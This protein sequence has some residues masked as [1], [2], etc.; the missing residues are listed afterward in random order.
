MQG[1]VIQRA[2]RWC[3]ILLIVGLPASLA[4]QITPA[5]TAD[6]AAN[7]VAQV[8]VENTGNDIIPCSFCSTGRMLVMTWDGTTP[9]LAWDHNGTP[10]SQLLLGSTSLPPY[11]P[12][13]PDIVVGNGGEN[14]VVTYLLASRVFLEA[15]QWDSGTSQ[16]VALTSAPVLV[17]NSIS[18]IPNISVDA[19][20]NIVITWTR[21]MGASFGVWAITGD[22]FGNLTGSPV[23][24]SQPDFSPQNYICN[25]SD[26]SIYKSF[27]YGHIVNFSYVAH[28]VN[29]NTMGIIHKTE[30]FSNLQAG[31]ANTTPATIAYTAP[32]ND[33]VG[34]S[35]ITAMWNWN[36]PSGPNQVEI[37]F[38]EIDASNVYYYLRGYHAQTGLVSTLNS[39]FGL[40]QCFNSLPAVT[41]WGDKIFGGWSYNDDVP[42]CNKMD[43]NIPSLPAATTNEVLVRELGFNGTPQTLPSPY[44][45]QN[46]HLPGEQLASSLAGR[47][48][49]ADR[50]FLVHYDGDQQDVI[51]KV[52]DFTSGAVKQ[53][54][55]V[56]GLPT[57]GNMGAEG[58][59]LYPNPAAD[60]LHIRRPDFAAR[61]MLLYDLF[62]SVVQRFNLSEGAGDIQVDVSSV[63]EGAYVVEL[64]AGD[65]RHRMPLRI[66]R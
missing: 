31:I 66:I 12:E 49:F 36:D 45:L 25:Q 40:E 39:V 33:K 19:A 4:A 52:S 30:T 5:A 57:S 51:Y 2:S 58:L 64:R 62:G 37:S 6:A 59:L 47:R 65:R 32:T 53:G 42:G 27:S 7:S 44:Y 21:K 50:L 55:D 60:M 22:I 28:H 16:F 20:D 17:Q 63:S 34:S 61:E 18:Q 29:S 35:R 23:N 8:E 46:V 38:I 24:I 26:V 9:M 43:L 1:N 56:G 15:W 41:H 11:I 13:D 14:L 54:A 48:Q 3:I 10:A